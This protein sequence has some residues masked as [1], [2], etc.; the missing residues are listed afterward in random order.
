MINGIIDTTGVFHKCARW[1]HIST[2]LSL[3]YASYLIV[4]PRPSSDLFGL[5][6]VEVDIVGGLNKKQIDALYDYCTKYELVIENVI[7]SDLE[8]EMNANTG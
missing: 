5:V 1:K 8:D 2:A 7:S 6:D 4:S 3:G